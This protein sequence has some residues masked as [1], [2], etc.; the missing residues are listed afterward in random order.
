MH[1]QILRDLNAWYTG[2]IFFPHNLE[3]VLLLLLYI[4]MKLQ[5]VLG[6][7]G[8]HII[9]LLHLLK[10]TNFIATNYMKI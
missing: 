2:A 3:I 10:C 7:S 6:F 5:I 8:T 9:V 4:T 1:T